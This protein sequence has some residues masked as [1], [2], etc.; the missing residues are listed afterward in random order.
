MWNHRS[1]QSRETRTAEDF[2]APC[3]SSPFPSGIKVSRFLRVS[4]SPLTLTMSSTAHFSRLCICK[5]KWMYVWITA[6]KLNKWYQTRKVLLQNCTVFDHF[7]SWKP[8][9][10]TKGSNYCSQ[11]HHLLLSVHN[12]AVH[13]G[14]LDQWGENIFILTI[15]SLFHSHHQPRIRT[16]LS[17]A[18]HF[19]IIP[20]F[21]VL[22]K[23]LFSFTRIAQ[24]H[25]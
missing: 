18:Y 19:R 3:L 14:N 25:L 4:S 1:E 7:P 23:R 17:G 15:L 9:Q 13:K 2:E 5:L 8:T 21:T 10:T 11:T 12:A 24:A 6:T 22:V 20:V 16:V